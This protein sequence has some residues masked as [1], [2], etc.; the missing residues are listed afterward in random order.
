M[1]YKWV[2]WKKDAGSDKVWGV[3]MNSPPSPDSW[4]I[5]GRYCV[6]WGRRGAK[7][8]TKI[9]LVWEW[10]ID[11]LIQKKHNKGYQLVAP[12]L[13]NTIYPGFEED[14]KKTAMW[15]VLSS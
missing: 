15:S 9:H 3:I 10:S 13:L 1:K 6:F 2:G 4:D 12:E 14:L 7:L 5:P 11:D 8:Q